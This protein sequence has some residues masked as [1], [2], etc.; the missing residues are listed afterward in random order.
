MLNYTKMKSAVKWK[1]VLL[2][3]LIAAGPQQALS[4]SN[5]FAP[6]WTM[7][8][9]ASTLRF[10]SVKSET[11]V[12]SSTFGTYTGT[13]TEDGLATVRILMDSVDTNVD[14]RNVRPGRPAAG[15]GWIGMTPRGAFQTADITVTPLLPAWLFLLLASLLIV[16]AWLREGRR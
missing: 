5:V 13:I 6:G 1:H 4:Q 8:A 11:K 9:E 3:G 15:R 12:E 16:G 2:A 7:D 10:Q 14:L